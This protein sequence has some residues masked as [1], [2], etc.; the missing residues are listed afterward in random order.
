MTTAQAPCLSLER[1]MEYVGDMDGVMTL[2]TTLQ[3][4]LRA[5]LPQIQSLFDAGDL[6]GA[7]RLLHQLKG[8]VPVF[9]VDTLVADVGRVEAL[10]K[11]TDLQG[12]RSA[13]ARLA[14]RLQQFLA[15]VQALLAKPR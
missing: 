1:A 2:L 4:S 12:A 8:F 9:C 13:Y 6:P 10:S 7:N 5:D 3:S 14:P 11:G 15:E